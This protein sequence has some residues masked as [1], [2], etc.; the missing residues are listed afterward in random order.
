MRAEGWEGVPQESGEK[1][2]MEGG[3]GVEKSRV[4]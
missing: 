2:A 3:G 4:V 1:R